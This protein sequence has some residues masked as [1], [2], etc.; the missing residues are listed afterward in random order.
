MTTPPSDDGY[1]YASDDTLYEYHSSLRSDLDEL[2]VAKDQ[3]TDEFDLMPKERKQIL[4]RMRDRYVHQSVGLSQN[5]RHELDASN[6]SSALDALVG[7][8]VPQGEPI[9]RNDVLGIHR[10][11]LNG[12][13]PNAAEI[14]A[15]RTRDVE[16]DQDTTVPEHFDV[17]RLMDEF[18]DWLSVA[19]LPP[20]ADPLVVAS[21]AHVWL[22]RIHPFVNGNGR[23]ARL[24]MALILARDGYPLVSITD[25]NRVAYMDALKKSDDF[26]ISDFLKLIIIAADEALRRYRELAERMKQ[27]QRKV[28]NIAQRVDKRI[29]IKEQNDYHLWSREMNSLIGEFEVAR[30]NFSRSVTHINISEVWRYEPFLP[31]YKFSGLR[32]RRTPSRTGV[33]ALQ[34][35]SRRQNRPYIVRYQFFAAFAS[36][37][38]MEH[39]DISLLI[40]RD[41]TDERDHKWDYD[42]LDDVQA[43]VPRPDI[44]ELAFSVDSQEWFVRRENGIEPIQMEKIAPEFINDVVKCEFDRN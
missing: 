21:I 3:L 8:F 20:V 12:I 6:Y 7:M 5:D 2:A 30:G 1:V 19:T 24:V 15:L 33:F 32:N 31:Y 43:G 38:M 17:P 37:A 28:I 34:I 4:Q 26:D 23:T 35:I 44:R 40:S 10:Q 11:L 41:A 9:R 14:G 16:L 18:S 22:T 36:E 42:M 29:E 13:L 39:A 27:G 25:E